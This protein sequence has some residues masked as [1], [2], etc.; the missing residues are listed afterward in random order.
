M[1]A[2]G[3]ILLLSAVSAFPTGFP[4]VGFNVTLNRNGT[5]NGSGIL[6]TGENMHHKIEYQFL[7]F[8]MN[9]TAPF[10]TN[11]VQNL[12][13]YVNMSFGTH[14]GFVDGDNFTEGGAFTSDFPASPLGYTQLYS[15]LYN[16]GADNKVNIDRT[17]TM[18]MC[19]FFYEKGWMDVWIRPTNPAIAGAFREG[20]Y[21]CFYNLNLGKEIIHEGESRWSNILQCNSGS[22]NN[23]SFR[24]WYQMR[25]YNIDAKTCQPGFHSN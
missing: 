13:I 9:Q 24:L 14:P 17:I 18:D 10:A 23:Y 20:Y 2:L 25:F 21:T 15:G 4:P 8:Q 16:G 19:G 11:L 7:D 12:E 22:L 6:P 1:L 5:W 3:A